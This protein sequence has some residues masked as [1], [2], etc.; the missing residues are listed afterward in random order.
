M[1]HSIFRE[2]RI[3]S[4]TVYASAALAEIGGCFA[5]R[6]CLRFGKAVLWTVPGTAALVLFAVL[7]ARINSDFAGRAQAD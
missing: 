3:A 2:R 4:I 5:F 1:D 7:P 6:A